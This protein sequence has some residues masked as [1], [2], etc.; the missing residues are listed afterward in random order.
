MV[1]LPESLM[2]STRKRYL[3][4]DEDPNAVEFYGGATVDED[5]HERAL[6]RDMV[7]DILD[8]LSASW[9][10]AANRWRQAPKTGR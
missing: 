10:A 2:K 8:E 7:E 5:G 9:Q 1:G 6:T 4:L 3:S